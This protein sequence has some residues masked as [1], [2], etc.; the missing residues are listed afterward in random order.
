M[1]V[2]K[3]KG[4]QDRARRERGKCEGATESGK[5]DAN[6]IT[7]AWTPTFASRQSLPA[8]S[9]APLLASRLKHPA[10][11]WVDPM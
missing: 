8:A 5:A 3:L 1:A 9:E 7:T 4:E 11:S 6:S 2:A 10:G